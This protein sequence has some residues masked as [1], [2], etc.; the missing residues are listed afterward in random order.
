MST[1]YQLRPTRYCRACG[2]SVDADVVACTKCGTIQSLALM[3]IESEKRIVPTLA[4]CVFFGFLGVHRFYVG[5]VATGMLQLLTLGGL[6]IWVMVDMVL[7]I[8]GAFRDG[9][10]DRLTEWI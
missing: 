10:G 8:V 4:L 2:A 7:L 3:T 6:G 5:K 1:D 9:E